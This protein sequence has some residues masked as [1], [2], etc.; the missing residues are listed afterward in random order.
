MYLSNRTAGQLPTAASRRSPPEPDEMPIY[1]D[2]QHARRML[3]MGSVMDAVRGMFVG[4]AEGRVTN[5]PRNRSP[6]FDRSLNVTAA[7][8]E[9][10]QRFAVKVYGAGG[11]HILL[12]HRKQGLL[13]IM[14]ADW[15]GQMRTG[16]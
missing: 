7:T 5:V 14:E 6:V 16:A 4:Q 9:A 10:S 1:L 11:F 12:Y 8:D 15:L 2:E 13:A 3:D